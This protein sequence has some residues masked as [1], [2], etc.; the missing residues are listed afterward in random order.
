MGKYEGG[1][2]CLTGDI[3]HQMG[4][5]EQSYLDKPEVSTAKEYLRI[6]EKHDIKVTL[7]ITG[8]TFLQAG[9]MIKN[10]LTFK[11]FEIG[12]HTWNA[13]RP[14]ILHRFFNVL[15]SSY[16]GP[17]FY[18]AWDIRKTL[19]IIKEKT[20]R[21]PKSWR[22]HSYK[23]NQTTY[24]LLASYGVEVV[25]D[26]VRKGKFHPITREGEPVQLPINVLPD[27]S[28]VV[29]GRNN[30]QHIK[31]IG[32]SGTDF[33]TNLYRS[34]EWLSLVKRQT[35]KICKEGGIATLLV[36][37]LCQRIIDNFKTF[38]KLVRFLANFQTIHASEAINN[39]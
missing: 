32:W 7:F 39:N 28:H 4:T 8:K 30:Y 24:K 10:L 3:H 14:R 31:E 37:P 11:N 20:G 25:S 36:H 18:Q 27:H 6:T 19:G 34:D 12:G 26:E 5:F 29:H 13:F 15:T 22:T 9:E 1:K 23:S 33:G 38:E 16:Y 17:K 21:K 2:V 35:L